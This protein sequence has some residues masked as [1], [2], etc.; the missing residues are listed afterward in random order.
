MKQI[1]FFAILLLFV[2]SCR[3]TNLKVEK[4]TKGQLVLNFKNQTLSSFFSDR[5][6]GITEMIPLETTDNCLI[7]QDPDFKFDGHH[8]FILDYQQQFILRFEKSG[9][10]INQIGRSGE[11]PGEYRYLEDYDIDSDANVV[12]IL[13]SGQILRYNYDGTFISSIKIGGFPNSFIKTGNTY[14]INLG[15][16]KLAGDGRLLK[17][18]EDGTV[19]EKFLPFKKDWATIV[20]QCFTRSGDMISFKEYLSRSVYRITD[21][22]PVETT[23]IDFGKYAIPKNLYGRNMPSA[24]DALR[25][26]SYVTIE[27]Y[28]ENNKFIYIFFKI[29]YG[30]DS[31]L[32]HWLVNKNTEN[33]VLQKLSVDDPLWAMMENAKV[34]TD[35]DE[36]IF[37]ANAQH[38]KESTD[39]FF[40][41]TDS[42]LDSLSEESNPVIISVKINDF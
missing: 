33:S 39:P 30:N 25:S 14:W 18:S 9:K 20:E 29:K 23:I 1:L 38:L 37:M 16:C 2:S 6:L 21:D 17:V 10:F 19:V 32:Y 4:N 5:I 41:S 3:N 8:F 13:G 24:L 31:D 12:E 15:M 40:N 27:K 11:G 26:K 7:G 36:L 22:G 34:L 28:L 42:I 35:D